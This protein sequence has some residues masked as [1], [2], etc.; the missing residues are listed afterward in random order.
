[1]NPFLIKFKVIFLSFNGYTLCYKY[2][3]PIVSN[4][5]T[6]MKWNQFQ[7]RVRPMCL[8]S[9]H[10]KDQNEAFAEGAFLVKS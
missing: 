2:L 1:M 9:S 5:Q 10:A 7:L 3:N 8:N 6:N 4:V